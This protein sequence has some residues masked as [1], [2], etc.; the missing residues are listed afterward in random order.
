MHWRP[1]LRVAHVAPEFDSKIAALDKRL[2]TIRDQ[3]KKS[4]GSAQN[5]LK[6]RALQILKQKVR[7][8]AAADIAYSHGR[9]AYIDRKCTAVC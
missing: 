7:A 9:W 6:Q 8:A 5:T 2:R 4:R 3:M 1:L